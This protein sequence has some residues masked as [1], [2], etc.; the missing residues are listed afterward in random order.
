MEETTMKPK[1]KSYGEEAYELDNLYNDD[2]N[3]RYIV[4]ETSVWY[5]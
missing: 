1:R 5:S 3:E 2:V 4:T